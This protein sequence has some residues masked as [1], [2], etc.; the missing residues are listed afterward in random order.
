M[1]ALNANKK[2]EVLDSNALKLIAILA[3][4]LDHLAW[5]IWPGFSHNPF[6]VILH[7]IG[8]LTCPIMCYFIAEGYHYTKNLKKYIARMFLFA[9]ISHFPYVFCS[10]NYVD[11]WSFLPFAYGSPFNQT[12]VL[13]GF[14]WGLVLIKIHDSQLKTPLKILLTFLILAISFPAD[15][16]CIAPMV[17]LSFWSNRGNFKKQMLWM[18]FWVFVYGVVYFFA[19]DKIY[20]FIQ[21]AVCLAIPLLFLYNGRRGKSV[22]FN[23]LLK[24]VFYFYYPLHFAIIGILTYFGVF[25]IF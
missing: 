16:S 20:A 18:M 3:M 14:A 9:V 15:W 11:A 12:G 17:I 22:V 10:F 23:K 24:W 4:T 19:I 8:R 1:E 13:W 6:A 25:P 7:I 21:L 2:Y 5:A